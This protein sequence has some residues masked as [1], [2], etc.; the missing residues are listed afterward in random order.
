MRSSHRSGGEPDANPG[1]HR[2]DAAGP[3]GIC[4]TP[5]IPLHGTAFEERMDYRTRTD[6]RRHFR[7]RGATPSDLCPNARVAG[8]IRLG[9][10]SFLRRRILML[11]RPDLPKVAV[12][13][14][15]MRVNG[16]EFNWSMKERCRVAH[17]D[18]RGFARHGGKRRPCRD[19][20]DGEIARCLASARKGRPRFQHGSTNVVL[21]HHAEGMTLLRR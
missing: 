19:G 13:L 4:R 7:K 9:A 1:A 2:S 18:I 17:K 20:G 21:R 11:A 8:V 16:T 14:H 6:V 5:A 10:R 15:R 12:I 3:R